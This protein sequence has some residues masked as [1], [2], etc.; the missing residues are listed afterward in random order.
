MA[1]EWLKCGK[2]E[3]ELGCDPESGCMYCEG[4]YTLSPTPED[5]GTGNRVWAGF[6][7]KQKADLA[8]RAIQMWHSPIQVCLDCPARGQDTAD[9][10]PHPNPN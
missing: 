8:P 10:T 4:L 7:Q 5:G 1:H 2:E 3:T 9:P 6:G